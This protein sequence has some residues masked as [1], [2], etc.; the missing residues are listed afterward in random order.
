[1]PHLT[2]AARYDYVRY[3]STPDLPLKGSAY[4][5]QASL[6]FEYNLFVLRFRHFD[7][8]IPNGDAIQGSNNDFRAE[9]RFLF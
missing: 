8:D 3:N 7:S 9:W 4:T 1:M 5:I 2:V 6:P